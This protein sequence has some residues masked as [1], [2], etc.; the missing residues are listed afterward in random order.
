MKLQDIIY[1]NKERLEKINTPKPTGD[2]HKVLI[3]ESK[4]AH[5]DNVIEIEDCPLA[6]NFNR[7]Y[8]ALSVGSI[9]KTINPSVKLY[10]M[11]LEIDIEPIIIWCIDNN[12]R[13]I[14]MSV[15]THDTDERIEQLKRYADWGG[16]VVGA[17][18]NWEGHSVSFPADDENSIGVSATNTEDTNGEE[19]DITV[20]SWW[21]AKQ[22]GH[23]RLIGFPG[24]SG[25]APIISGVATHYLEANPN[26]NVETF[27]KWL[28]RNSY[29]DIE[30]D[31]KLEEGERFF[32]FPDNLEDEEINMPNE[33]KDVIKLYPRWSQSSGKPTYKLNDKVK[34]M[35][36]KPFI[37]NGRT[38]VP[39]RFVAEALGCEIEWNEETGEVKII[40]NGQND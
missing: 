12:V 22:Y 15:A 17:S 30:V 29:T 16:I 11:H 35:D 10:T 25:S 33:N 9:I 39:I 18:G 5:K 28:K 2:T 14:N 38:F 24:T 36:V 8:H 7:G 20:E 31:G 40:Q 37:E 6:D 27:R 21:R 13:V 19:V 32:V 3:L 4:L 23:D 26:G 1:S 34:S